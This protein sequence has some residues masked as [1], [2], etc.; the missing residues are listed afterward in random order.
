MTSNS[1]KFQ[2]EILYTPLPFFGHKAIFWGEGEGCKFEPHR[3]RNFIHPPPSFVHLPPLDRCCQAWGDGGVLNL[4]PPRIL[5]E[6]LGKSPG[7]RVCVGSLN[8]FSFSFLC[9]GGGGLSGGGRNSSRNRRNGKGVG[10]ERIETGSEGGRDT[11]GR[12]RLVHPWALLPGSVALSGVKDSY[13]IVV[14]VGGLSVLVISTST[15]RLSD[16]KC[17]QA[18]L[19]R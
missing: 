2:A 16:S 3:E 9:G 14:R 6:F 10:R 5:A 8:T 17:Q 13:P 19:C 15:D 1:P 18:C 11:V 12:V 7:S 4:A